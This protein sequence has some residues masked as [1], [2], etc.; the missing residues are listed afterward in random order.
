MT[1]VFLVVI[2][3]FSYYSYN[4]D[5]NYV[6][7]RERLYINGE[8]Y[9]WFGEWWNALQEAAYLS[10]NGPNTDELDKYPAGWWLGMAVLVFFITVVIM[11]LVIAIISDIYTE[12]MAEE[13]EI[14]YWGR[15]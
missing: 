4:L 12:V 6:V 13:F 5:L 9:N 2:R 1:S 10:I 14:L 7:T 8:S 15:M 3:Q 11:N